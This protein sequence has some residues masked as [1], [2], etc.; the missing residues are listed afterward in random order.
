MHRHT[1][2]TS[3]VCVCMWVGV[4]VFLRVLVC[5][6]VC[7]MCVNGVPRAPLIEGSRRP[8]RACWEKP[9]TLRTRR[10]CVCRPGGLR[11]HVPLASPVSP[12]PLGLRLRF[13]FTARP[14]AQMLSNGRAARIRPARIRGHHLQHAVRL[15]HGCINL[16]VVPNGRV[17][18]LHRADVSLISWLAMQACALPAW[19]PLWVPSLRY[20]PATFCCAQVVLSRVS[21]GRQADGPFVLAR[22]TALAL[23]SPPRLPPSSQAIFL[24]FLE[25]LR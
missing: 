9:S 17:S 3:H 13:A 25:K 12:G 4:L 14:R 15:R 18:C 16:T 1:G 5:D 22:R 20:W 11:T 8:A 10:S 6:S 19:G 7:L 23:F 21:L 24:G 2:D